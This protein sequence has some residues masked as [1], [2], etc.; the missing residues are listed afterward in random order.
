MFIQLEVTEVTEVTEVLVQ[1]DW[2]VLL[3]ELAVLEQVQVLEVN[4]MLE[5]WW[6]SLRSQQEQLTTQMFMLLV[7]LQFQLEEMGE[8]QV[9]V[10]REVLEAL[11]QLVELEQR[12]VQVVWVERVMLEV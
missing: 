12:M 6:E 1:M 9:L 7:Q 8:I 5:V 10:E 2:Q 3:V 4:Q 11:E